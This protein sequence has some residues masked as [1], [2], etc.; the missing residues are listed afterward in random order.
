VHKTGVI[1]S[2]IKIENIVQKMSEVPEEFRV[3]K[4]IDFGLSTKMDSNGQA[5][6]IAKCGTFGYMAP[7]I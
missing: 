4:L 3:S 7:E 6:A 1:H 2:D 5:T